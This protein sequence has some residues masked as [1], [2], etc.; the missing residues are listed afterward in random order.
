[1]QEFIEITLKNEIKINFI[2]T[3]KNATQEI[4]CATEQ[5]CIYLK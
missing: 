3:I 4:A 2:K 1:M 5:F